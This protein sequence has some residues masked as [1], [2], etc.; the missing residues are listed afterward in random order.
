MYVTKEKKEKKKR[1]KPY[2]NVIE[3]KP[4]NKKN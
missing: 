4:P 2:T 3:Q 1:Q